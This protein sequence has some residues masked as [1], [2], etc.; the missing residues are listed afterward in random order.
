MAQLSAREKRI[1]A[2]TLLGEAAGEGRKGMEAVAWVIRN[3]AESGRY[4]SKPSA[5]ALQNNGRVYQFSTWNGDPTSKFST[6]S[7]SYKTA[8][9]AID[10]VFAAD[11]SA[12]PTRGATHY[13]ASSG[14][15][16]IKKPR[17]FD[18]E[19][20]HGAVQIGNHSFS[21]K[22]EAVQVAQPPPYIPPIPPG[23]NPIYNPPA[24]QD[25]PLTFLTTRKVQTYKV[26]NEGNPI[27]P[28]A[29]V[30]VRGS[31]APR[32][33]RTVL[34]D[35]QA[36]KA[37]YDYLRELKQ[38]GHINTKDTHYV[39]SNGDTIIRPPTAGNFIMPPGARPDIEGM[40][41]RNQGRDLGTGPSWTELG[42]WQ[43]WKN[44]PFIMGA[45]RLPKGNQQEPPPELQGMV[46]IGP[47][48]RPRPKYV[49]VY[50]TVK[51]QVQVGVTAPDEA[52]RPRG[53]QGRGSHRRQ[54]LQAQVQPKMRTITVQ[55]P[56]Q[57]AVYTPPPVQ[58]TT[59]STGKR[60]PIGA[61]SSSQG[62]RYQYQVQK[63][64]SIRNLTTG[65]VT[66]GQQKVSGTTASGLDLNSVPASQRW[67]AQYM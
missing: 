48:P 19:G 57:V 44:S 15:N 64:G 14:A 24:P 45:A 37:Y 3:R 29:E 35:V 55:Q 41:E 39:R 65:R 42:N 7:S 43:A 21:A 5:V 40:I 11:D 27:I 52:T 30:I 16:A 66:P 47:G 61:R 12:D 51:K 54:A 20:G 4:P 59:I 8:L 6:K 17:W 31:N 63:D 53:P 1:L 56:R 9:D 58:Y 13:Y 50:D 10:A 34:E 67:A 49:T 23:H 18:A 32:R 25:R 33:S 36:T 22:R 38:N 2:Y 60:V 28:D 26:D 62:G 46:D